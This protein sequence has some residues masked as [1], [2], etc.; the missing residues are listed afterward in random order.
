MKQQILQTSLNQFLKYGIRKMSIQ[1]LVEPLGISTK[2]VYKYFKNKEDLLEEALHLYYAQQYQLLE[3]YAAAQNPAHLLFDV[4]FTAIEQSSNV[5]TVFF[6]DLHY[7]Y[8]DLEKKIEVIIGKKFD[9]QFIGIIGKGIQEDIF[10][11]DVE[12]QIAM[13]GV[14]VLYN[15]IAKN[16]QFKVKGHSTLDILSNTIGLTIRGMCTAKGLE[17][18]DSHIQSVIESGGVKVFQETMVLS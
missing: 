1:K 8:P 13:E 15:A 10:R 7:Y 2:T 9:K 4:W 3:N 14:Y 16:E 18:L 5:N 12:P 6:R 17:D 11:G